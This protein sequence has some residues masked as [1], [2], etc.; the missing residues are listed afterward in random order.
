MSRQRVAERAELIYGYLRENLNEP[1]SIHDLLGAL[2]MQPTNTTRR[3]I[4]KARDLAES[5]GLCFPIA[6]PA[7]GNTYCVTDDPS[8]AVDPSLHLG[9]IALGVGV[10][11]DVHDDFIRSRMAQLSPVERSMFHSIEKYEEAQRASRVAHQE[12]IKAMVGMR[13]AGRED[14]SL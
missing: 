14:E 12:V 1:H 9:S 5:D 3:A 8:A 4:R 2:S 7:N 6:C 13:R 11:K 10:R